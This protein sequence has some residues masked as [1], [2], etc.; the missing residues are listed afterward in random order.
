MPI[1][2]ST[3]ASRVDPPLPLKTRIGIDP[4]DP[5]RSLFPVQTSNSYSFLKAIQQSSIINPP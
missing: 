3:P 1:A 4:A 5:K 2:I